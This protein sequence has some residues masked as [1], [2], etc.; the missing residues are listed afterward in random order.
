MYDGVASFFQDQ[1]AILDEAGNIITPGGRGQ[2][3]IH[4]AILNEHVSLGTVKLMI[5]W[6]PESVLIAD[7]CGNI[8]LHLAC[9]HCCMDIIKCLVNS[10]AG[11]VQ[12]KDATG[13]LPIQIACRL[14]KCDVVKWIL[15][16]ANGSGVSMENKDG[17]LPIQLLLYEASC[18][19]DSLEYVQALNALLCAHPEAV[20]HLLA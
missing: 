20:A 1:F 17:K 12:I 4:R 16:M 10:D 8:P 19:R 15:D 5:D 3:P 6:N 18:D 13:D 14:G 7:R 11:T 9:Q 2:L